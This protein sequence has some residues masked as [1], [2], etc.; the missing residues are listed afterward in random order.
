MGG[1]RLAARQLDSAIF[2]ALDSR[3]LAQRWVMPAGLAR[4]FER[5]RSYL[6]DPYLLAVE[7][8]RNAT[9]ISAGKIAEPLASQLRNMIALEDDARYVL[10]PVELRFENSAG[11][12]RGVLRVAFLDPRAAEA[13][14]VGDVKGAPATTSAG[15]LMSVGQR[16]ADLFAAP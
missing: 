3:G 16:L 8:L 1:N 10:V 12:V 9:F 14:W 7:P 5:N 2:L 15:A 6:T 11:T 13:R 4:S